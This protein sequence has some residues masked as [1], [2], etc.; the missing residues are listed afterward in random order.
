M[1]LGGRST[2]ATGRAIVAALSLSACGGDAADGSAAGDSGGDRPTRWG[3][4]STR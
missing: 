4:T 1:S 3:R 2:T